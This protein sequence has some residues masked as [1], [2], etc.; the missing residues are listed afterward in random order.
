MLEGRKMPV[1][2][3]KRD[4]TKAVIHAHISDEVDDPVENVAQ[5]ISE[6]LDQRIKARE[7][8]QVP[9]ERLKP[10]P[11]NAKKHSH[12][13][14][15]LLAE[16]FEKWGVTQPIVVDEDNIILCGHGRFAAAAKI[17]LTH[18]PVVRLSGLTAA[19]RQALAIA[20][21]KLAELSEW[22]LEILSEEL[23]LLSDAE[24]EFDA[25]ILGFETVEI[26]QIIVDGT[27]PDR[28]DPADQFDGPPPEA[29]AVTK[30]GDVWVCDQ[31]RLL[32]GDATLR[33]NYT[34][35]L[36]DEFADMVF[37]DPPGTPPTRAM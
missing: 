24:L 21:N 35:L 18:L 14:I 27:K 17:K 5:Q 9:I 31:H 20:D 6:P 37:T 19:Q 4:Q 11:R 32:C 2:F 33:E 23:S 30:F 29:F 25:R 36:G 8:E 26:D 10:N 22:D 3:G 34:T 1:L 7:I 28:A 15:A 16:N 12:R 13:Q